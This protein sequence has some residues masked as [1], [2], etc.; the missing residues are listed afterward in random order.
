MFY[1]SVNLIRKM[2]HYYK[3]ETYNREF[4]ENKLLEYYVPGVHEG[5]LMRYTIWLAQESL[6]I[7]SM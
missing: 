1:A 4:M 3:F 7:V 5:T 2:S 6:I